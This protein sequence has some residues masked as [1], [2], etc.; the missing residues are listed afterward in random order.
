[1]MSS[2]LLW[3]PKVSCE[4]INVWGSG[5]YFK[6]RENR[7]SS[8]PVSVQQVSERHGSF[9]LLYPGTGLKWMSRRAVCHTWGRATA[10]NVLTFF[11]NILK[12]R[13][14]NLKSDIFFSS[15][16][17]LYKNLKYL[18]L[19]HHKKLT[20]QPHTD[21]FNLTPNLLLLHAV[22]L[23]QKLLYL[24]ALFHFNLK[25]KFVTNQ[26]LIKSEL[27]IFFCFDFQSETESTSVVRWVGALT[28]SLP[29]LK[30]PRTSSLLSAA[31]LVLL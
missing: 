21:T 12:S 26:S 23:P 30:F 2:H 20:L 14:S 29:V 19:L 6:Q 11:F 4:N 28:I 24:T 18:M 13:K 10:D 22:R 8:C 31:W 16:F 27:F 9:L 15:K 25:Q 5:V 7:A 17:S 3:S 1:M